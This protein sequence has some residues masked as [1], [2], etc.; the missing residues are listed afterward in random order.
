MAASASPENSQATNDPSGQPVICVGSAP[1][2]T[3]DDMDKVLAQWARER[4]DLDLAAMAILGRITRVA[5]LVNERIAQAFSE[6]GLDFSTFS[7]LARLRRTG[8]PY[9]LTPS[10]IAATMPI[11]A[12]AV[13]QCLSRLEEQ[14]FI[15][16]THDNPDR[17]KVTVALT[18]LGLSTIEAAIARHAEQQQDLITIYTDEE[19]KVFADL[20]KRL[21]ALLSSTRGV[22]EA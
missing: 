12:S 14:G 15:T 3:S 21:Y 2:G 4:P 22:P 8:S 18:P 16:R 20:L 11:T 19:Q 1:D 13:A 9:A 10:Q 5:P 6:F 17:R 7:I